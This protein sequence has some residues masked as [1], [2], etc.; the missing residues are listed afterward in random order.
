MPRRTHSTPITRSFGARM[1]DLRLE[2][3]M[4][5]DQLSKAT[6]IGKGHLSSIEQGFAS[7]TIESLV[8]IATGLELSPTMLVAFPEIDECAKILDLVRQLPTTRLKPL[9]KLMKQWIADCE[10]GKL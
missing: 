2:T 7:I 9:R 1:R 6:G 10:K 8:R 5:L 4:S 3:G